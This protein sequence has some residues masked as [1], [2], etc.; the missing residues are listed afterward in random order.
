VATVA[1]GLA[2]AGVALDEET[3][4]SRSDGRWQVRGAGHAWELAGPGAPLRVLRD[5]DVLP[6]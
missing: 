5:G 2:P 6:W 1:A 4:L 3:V